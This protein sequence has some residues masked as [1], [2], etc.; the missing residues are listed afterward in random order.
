MP[1]ISELSANFWLLFSLA[2]TIAVVRELR[3]GRS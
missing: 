2:V 1:M 3:R